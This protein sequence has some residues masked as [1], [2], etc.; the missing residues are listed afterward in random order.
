MAYLPDQ[1][2][3]V[4]KTPKSKSL[5]HS[6][7]EER[8]DIQS[9]VQSR[10]KKE[11]KVIS[12]ISNVKTSSNLVHRQPKRSQTSSQ[13]A[14]RSD[15]LPS[16]DI[17]IRSDSGPINGSFLTP[18]Y[19]IQD[20][21]SKLTIS[22]SKFAINGDP[23]HSTSVALD[24]ATHRLLQ[25][26]FSNFIETVFNAESLSLAS[27][28]PANLYQRTFRHRQA[29]AERLS[30]C[31]HDDLILYATLS[32]CSSCIK[33]SVGEQRTTRPPEYYMLKAIKRLRLRLNGL[34][35]VDDWLIVAMYA[36]SVTEMW[37]GNS[38]AATLHLKALRKCIE[39]K[40][41]MRSLEPYVMESLI[42][43]DKYTAL[44]NG[45]SPVLPF[46]WDPGPLSEEKARMISQH[47]DATSFTIGSGFTDEQRKDIMDPEL[48]H[49]IRD[50]VQ[51][52]HFA[53]L[54]VELSDL[55][56]QWL[57]LRNSSFMYR[58]LALDASAQPFHECCRLGLII[59]VL[60]ITSYAG[61][62]GHIKRL[63]PRLKAEMTILGIESKDVLFTEHMGILFWLTALGAMASEYID[64]RDWFIQQTSH[65]GKLLG[66]ALEK[67]SYKSFLRKFLFIKGEDGLNFA[68]IIRRAKEL[69]GQPVPFV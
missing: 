21:Q 66:L 27:R 63:L 61:A 49:I 19:W 13:I 36:L 31:V 5:S 64:E 50:M 65:L 10:Q 68:R 9:H 48:L 11:T 26:P 67:E 58:L 8:F 14:S 41:G 42:L 28:S 29:I 17:T 2:L 24:P 52:M 44:L 3:F 6:N 16:L 59:W 47:P 54:A 7:Q 12:K 53:E 1:F 23:F 4:N 60:K 45:T 46:D 40:G 43:S 38:A 33:W 25:Y 35:N 30:R 32:Y 57:F 20:K 55:D 15:R 56:Q 51:C 62:R 18:Q 22:P 34:Q 69:E 37:T 39:Q